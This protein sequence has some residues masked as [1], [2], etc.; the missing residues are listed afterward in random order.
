LAFEEEKGAGH[1]GG[2]AKFQR[3]FKKAR[4]KRKAKNQTRQNGAGG[5]KRL[6]PN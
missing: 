4:K 3:T 5:E 1:R 6:P 2:L